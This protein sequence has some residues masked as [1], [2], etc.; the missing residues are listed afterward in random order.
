MFPQ[1]TQHCCYSTAAPPSPMHETLC[2]T[3]FIFML[4]QQHLHGLWLWLVLS[5]QPQHTTVSHVYTQ[6]GLRWPSVT[7]V[8]GAKQ[9]IV[10]RVLWWCLVSRGEDTSVNCQPPD[11]NT[12]RDDGEKVYTCTYILSRPVSAEQ[13]PLYTYIHI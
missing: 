3:M 5:P 11:L 10:T 13:R 6:S 8:P 1:P 9:Y 4:S 12:A 7:H 2:I